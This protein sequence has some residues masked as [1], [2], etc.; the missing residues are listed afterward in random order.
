MTVTLPDR[1]ACVCGTAFGP[2]VL[3]YWL[4]CEGIVTRGYGPRC[5]PRHI[6]A[7]TALAE[8]REPAA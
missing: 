6:A 1:P 4:V 3:R 8:F 2:Q 5:A 7:A